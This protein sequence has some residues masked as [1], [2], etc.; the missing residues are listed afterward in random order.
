METSVQRVKQYLE[1]KNISP[2]AFYSTTGLSNGYLNNVKVLGSD[3]LEI[4]LKCYPD[5]NVLWVVTGKGSM[6]NAKA[7]GAG[8][9]SDQT[10]KDTQRIM[11]ELEQKYNVTVPPPAGDVNTSIQ[12]L[13]V[14]II[15]QTELLK[16]L[17]KEMRKK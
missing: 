2:S 14:R 5:L 6:Y 13:K 12:D 8:Y 16:E 11:Q 7:K 9:D 17:L 15:E 1:A 4:I 10:A 3:K